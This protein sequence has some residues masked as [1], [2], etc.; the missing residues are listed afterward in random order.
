MYAGSDTVDKVAWYSGN[1]SPTGTKPVGTLA[2]NDLGL[3]DMS[4]NVWEWCW[5]WYGPYTNGPET[6]PT[7]PASP[8][9]PANRVVRGGGYQ[10]SEAEVRSVSRGGTLPP[11]FNT[12]SDVGFRVVR[13]L[14]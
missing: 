10:Q 8:P 14:Q 3:Y 1:N 6:D 5:D 9:T 12:G 7:G 11:S 2:P 4:G 13:P